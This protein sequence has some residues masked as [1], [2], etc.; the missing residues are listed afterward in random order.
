M[1]NEIVR[2]AKEI[3]RLAGYTDRGQVLVLAARG[4]PIRKDGTW[5]ASKE[6]LLAWLVRDRRGGFIPE[7]PDP[8]RP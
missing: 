5:C 2:G 7:G 3:V 4:A 8:D 1:D 6:E